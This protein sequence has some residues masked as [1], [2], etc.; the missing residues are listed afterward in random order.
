M[1][2]ADTE[3]FSTLVKLELSALRYYVI[4]ALKS[5][6]QDKV[7]EFFGEN[8]NYLLQKRG[9]WLAWFGACSLPSFSYI[10]CTLLSCFINLNNIMQLFHILRTQAWIRSSVYISPK[11]GWTLWFFHSGIF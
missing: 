11:S 7:I 10:P 1:S 5:G 9:D 3:L 8:G 6:R 2:P 4:N